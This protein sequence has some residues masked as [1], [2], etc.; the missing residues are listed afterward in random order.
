MT[1]SFEDVPVLLGEATPIRETDKAVLFELDGEE[2][3]IPK[4][5]IHADS[6][7]WSESDEPGSLVVNRWWAEKNGYI[8]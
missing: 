7:V 4:S 3:W 2:I 6:E 5:V 8:S 1:R